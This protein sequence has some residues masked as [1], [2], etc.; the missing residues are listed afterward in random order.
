[1]RSL[2]SQCPNSITAFAR[3]LRE[4]ESRRAREIRQR[5]VIAI[6]E[7]EQALEIEAMHRLEQQSVDPIA[8]QQSR[9]RLD[10]L[11]WR[12]NGR[13]LGQ[14]FGACSDPRSQ[15]MKRYDSPQEDWPKIE[16]GVYAAGVRQIDGAS[17][18][19]SPCPGHVI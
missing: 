14:P 12:R 7:V 15:G 6:E 5:K 16:E 13:F 1:M 10:L 19:Q 4:P 17:G 11:A 8:V 3:A 9:E 2:T 18:T